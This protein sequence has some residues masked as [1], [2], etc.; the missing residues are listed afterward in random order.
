MVGE[1]LFSTR[2]DLGQCACFFFPGVVNSERGGG[3]RLGAAENTAVVGLDGL[4]SQTFSHFFI[5]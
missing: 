5:K 2:R 3:R 1:E 4:G